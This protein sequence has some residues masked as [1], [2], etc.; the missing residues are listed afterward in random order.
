MDL[1][2]QSDVSAAMK[3]IIKPDKKV[4]SNWIALVDEK[5]DK[6]IG[7]NYPMFLHTEKVQEARW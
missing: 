1:C 3:N 6:E 5:V 4:G 7:Y 2:Q